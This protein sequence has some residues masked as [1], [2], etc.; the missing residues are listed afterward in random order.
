MA[1]KFNYASGSGT[2]TVAIPEGA[3]VLLL[4]VEPSVVNQTTLQINNGDVI[5][6][7]V[8]FSEQPRGFMQGPMDIV[9]TSSEQY[10]VS[11][12]AD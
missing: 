2:S 1:N 5:T 3:K 12:V 4:T 10:Y 7:N 6:L 8:N 11:W 9:F